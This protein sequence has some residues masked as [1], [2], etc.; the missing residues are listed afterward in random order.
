MI[1]NNKFSIFI[2]INKNIPGPTKPIVVIKRLTDNTDHLL[3]ISE[4]AK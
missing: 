1:A 2:K 3:T 4:S